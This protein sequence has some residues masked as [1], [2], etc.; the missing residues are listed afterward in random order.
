M[1]YD[2]FGGTA[3]EYMSEAGM[4][5]SRDDDKIDFAIACHIGDYFKGGTH[6]DNHLFQVLRFNRLLS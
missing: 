6:L 2:P 5:M 3:H 1:P 4:A